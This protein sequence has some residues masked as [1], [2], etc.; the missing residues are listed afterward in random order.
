MRI[1]VQFIET[2]GGYEDAKIRMAGWVG[3][4]QNSQSA[5]PRDVTPP[6]PTLTQLHRVS[7]IFE[8]QE[9]TTTPPPRPGSKS[10]QYKIET[11]SRRQ[12]N[13]SSKAT[14]KSLTKSSYFVSFSFYHQVVLRRPALYLQGNVS[15]SQLFFWTIRRRSSYSFMCHLSQTC[16]AKST[17][18]ESGDCTRRG[19]VDKGNGGPSRG[20][21]SSP[22]SK[23][24][25]GLVG[26][27]SPTYQ[28]TIEVKNT[29][30][31]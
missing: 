22:S 18:S 31:I 11:R 15:R 3:P 5:S 1:R 6:P 9:Q 25:F 19:N 24:L 30:Q 8:V 4:D 10:F 7:F 20:L 14:I 29:S 16:A 17:T 21:A 23:I 28:F 12:Q 13:N 27:V 26:T 2:E